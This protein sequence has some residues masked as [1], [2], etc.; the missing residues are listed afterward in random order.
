[1]PVQASGSGEGDKNVV[2][3]LVG[4]LIALPTVTEFEREQ[5]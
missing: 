5:G 2:P 4:N 1:M 3:S